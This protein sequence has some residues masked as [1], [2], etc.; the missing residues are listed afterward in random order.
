[1]NDNPLLPIVLQ[2][3]REAPEGLSEFELLKRID[4]AGAGV[5]SAAADANL[6]LFQKHFILMNAL[7][8]LQES[9]WADEQLWLHISPLR[10]VLEAPAEA[11][12]AR[13]VALDGE[14]ALRAYYLDWEQLSATDAD[15]VADLL[16]GFWQR[17]HVLDGRAAALAAL[18]LEADADW[19]SIRQQ[20]R[21][22]AAQTHPDRGGDSARFLVIREA[23]ELL[24]PLSVIES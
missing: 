12:Q 2:L 14:R 19:P 4:A 24:R 9:L 17:F 23:Y 13:A 16:A 18:Q 1:M 22:L 15:A 3:L 11:A 5:D 6:A 10:I 21:R 8:R 7:Y 20:Y